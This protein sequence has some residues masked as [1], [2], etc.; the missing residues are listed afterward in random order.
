MT[1]EQLGKIM[2]TL[3]RLDARSA[4][5]EKAVLGNGTPGL[6]QRVDELEADAERRKGAMKV[7]G[8]IAAGFWALLEYLFHIKGAK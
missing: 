2:E 6:T 8:V 4:L 5:M 3:G 1:D 7:I